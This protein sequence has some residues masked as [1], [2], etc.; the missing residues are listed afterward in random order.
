MYAG[1]ITTDDTAGQVSEEAHSTDFES[2]IYVLEADGSTA[3]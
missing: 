3:K 2:R 1:L